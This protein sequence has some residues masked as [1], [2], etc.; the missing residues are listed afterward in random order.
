MN[1]NKALISHLVNHFSMHSARIYIMVEIISSL[2]KVGD[3][4]QQK[5][6][7]GTSIKTKISS[8]TRRIQRFFAEE[9]LDPHMTSKLIYGFFDWGQK[10]TF[11]LDRTNW[12]FGI[13]DINFLVISGIYKGCSVPLCWILLPHQGN[14]KTETRINL[15]EM[16][17]SIVPASYIKFLL[18]DREFI[19]CE[20]FNYLHEKGI[21]FCIRIKENMLVTDTRQGGQIQLKNL[22]KHLL[23][24]QSRELQQSIDG[25]MLRI[26][27]TRI[28]SGELLILAVSGDEN[29]L[30]ALELYK[31]RWTIET[32][33]K[34]YKS[35][36]FNFENTHQKNLERLYK[37]MT[38]LTIAYAWAIKIGEIK[39]DLKPIRIK[40]HGRLE[41]SLF[42]YGFR[43]IQ[44]ILLKDT[45]LREQL[46]VLIEKISLRLPFSQE[47]ANVTVVY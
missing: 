45:D 30:D 5:I 22:F 17:L 39:N 9:F 7:Q 10:I 16:L 13:L 38:L 18:A 36:G 33:F 46:F 41:F 20:W 6:A 15:I 44:T 29:L 47:V 4:Q 12:R 14:S 42:S 11:T 35:S 3:V 25:V 27:G 31:Q 34:A 26:I 32:M 19:G 24:G 1:E 37:M 8:I 43:A 21:P 23:I 2:I 40:N 28:E